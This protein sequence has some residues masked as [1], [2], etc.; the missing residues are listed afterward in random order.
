MERIADASYLLSKRRER[1]AIR[2]PP[3]RI[4]KTVSIELNVVEQGRV[5]LGARKRRTML[6]RSVS[7]RK[8]QL[9]TIDLLRLKFSSR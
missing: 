5:R 9:T 6:S 8:V 2:K 3:L 7:R 4:R 1:S